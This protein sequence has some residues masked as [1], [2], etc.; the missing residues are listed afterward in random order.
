MKKEQDNSPAT[1]NDI[2]I[3][4]TIQ[5]F[6]QFITVNRLLS[7]YIAKETKAL[8]EKKEHAREKLNGDKT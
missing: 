5:H 1:A 4:D 7:L 6:Q 2:T 3:S 8:D